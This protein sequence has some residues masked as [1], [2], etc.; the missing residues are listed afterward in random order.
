MSSP[1]PA[2][3]VGCLLDVSASMREA[4]QAGGPEERATERLRAVLRAAL[5]LAQAEQRHN[6][7]ALVFVGVFGLDTDKG[8]PPVADLCGAADALL[9]DPGDHR[10]G[11]DLLIAR[12]NKGNASHIAKY[13]R[14]K[15]TDDEARIVDAHLDRHPERLGEFVDAIPSE[16]KVMITK[17]AAT[18]AGAVVGA[19]AGAVTDGLVGN[20][21]AAEIEDNAVE[22]SEALHL[23]RR[24]CA[25]WLQDFTRLVPRPVDDVIRLLKQLQKRSEADEGDKKRTTGDSSLLDTLRRYMYGCTPMRDALSRSLM[26]FDEHPGVKHR[27]LVLVSDGLSTD[28]DPLPLARD[29]QQSRVSIVT[30]YLTSGKT[31]APRR[32]YYRPADG[33]NSGQRM[34]FG[35]AAKV[36]GVTHP[37]PVL[38]SVGWDVPSAGE[39]ALYATVSSSAALDEFCSLLLSARFGSADA[40]LDVIGRISHDS[41]INDKHIVTCRNPS[42]QGQSATCYAHATAAIVHM[43]LLRIIGREDG[44]PSIEKVR[45]QIEDKFR[46]KP[47]GHNIEE[48]L[49][50]A[51]SWY[52]PLRFRPVDED[53]ARQAVL[54]RRPVLTTFHSSKSGWAVFTEHFKQRPDPPEEPLPALR[55]D[56]MAAHR[57][58]P[59]YGGHAVVLVTCNPGSLTFVNSWGDQ[60]GNKGSFSVEDHTVLELDGTSRKYPV[61]FYDVYWLES[62]LTVT[63]RQAY[64]ARVDEELRCRAAQYPSILELE[65]CCPHCHNNRPLAN[66][67]GSIRQVQCPHCNRSFTPEPGHLMEALYAREGIRD[68]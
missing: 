2:A 34:L 8:C 48:V 67:R 65:A 25:G 49:R 12:A 44:Y 15:L 29:L 58:L 17:L 1:P 35:M 20:N 32:L 61:N 39:V 28:G 38:T 18:V 16:A 41:Y 40:L 64:S 36:A 11:H 9:G 3:V 23:A 31:E 42:D 22:R 54:R 60:W 56:Q 6:P 13:I 21:A 5:K 19:V 24:V 53:S 51:I 46:P 4:L 27:V 10:S 50:E 55:R 52:R 62:E 30:V 68:V 66:F 43:A 63:E 26:V 33:W 45:E 59:S 47:C 57:S 14:E 7:N 37:I